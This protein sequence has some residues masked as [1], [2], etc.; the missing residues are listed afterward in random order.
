MSGLILKDRAKRF[1]EI[2]EVPDLVLS[3]LG[4]MRIFRRII[5]C[6]SE[7]ALSQTQILSYQ[8][9]VGLRKTAR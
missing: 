8:A 3:I 4:R 7:E 5:R 1:A 2:L 9:E 6:L